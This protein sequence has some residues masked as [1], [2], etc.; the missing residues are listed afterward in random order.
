MDVNIKYSLDHITDER[1]LPLKKKTSVDI[2]LINVPKNCMMFDFTKFPI[3]LLRNRVLLLSRVCRS[4][5]F[6]WNKCISN[7]VTTYTNVMM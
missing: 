1:M 3:Y 2:G 5:G 6:S 4:K 7:M